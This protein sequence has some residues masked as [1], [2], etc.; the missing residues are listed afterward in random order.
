MEIHV[1][2]H[3]SLVEFNACKGRPCISL[4]QPTHH[5]SHPD[6]LQNSIR[7]GDLINTLEASL[8]QQPYRIVKDLIAPLEALEKDHDFW[9]CTLDGLAVLSAPEF[10]R[11]YL[12]PRHVPELAIVADSFLFKPLR[13][14]LQTIDRYQVL[15]LNLNKLQLF[16]GNRSKLEMVD[17]SIE[18]PQSTTS[19]VIESHHKPQSTEAPSNVIQDEIE[20]GTER[21]FRA[22]DRT[23][24]KHHS[25]LSGLPLIL[26][27]LP[28]HLHQFHAISRNP[29]LM[30][31]SL[32]I[33]PESL[34]HSELE[35]RAWKVLNA[36][37]QAQNTS[38]SDLYTNKKAN[39]L[40]YESVA[41]IRYAAMAG[42]VT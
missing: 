28:E 26:V 6:N 38:R 8:Q 10:L 22:V 14:F 4:Y 35:Q 3:D 25:R 18:V 30:H 36:Y 39:S 20:K 40:G 13:R 17:I 23:V 1:L 9:G 11:I 29:F 27:A 16:E 33:N 5:R 15:V 24:L 31:Y 37:Q 12:L 21:Y 42:R 41:E 32:M 34:T 2:S 7:F 19:L